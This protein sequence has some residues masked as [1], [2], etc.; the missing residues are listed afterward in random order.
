M[1]KDRRHHGQAFSYFLVLVASALFIVILGSLVSGKLDK[2]F[3]A[4]I[5][6][7]GT[8]L[9]TGVIIAAAAYEYGSSK[10]SAAKDEAAR[11]PDSPPALPPGTTIDSNVSSTLKTPPVTDPKI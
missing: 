1:A 7:W 5:E 9:L 8:M 2:E 6:N 10:G 3:I 4:I 11:V